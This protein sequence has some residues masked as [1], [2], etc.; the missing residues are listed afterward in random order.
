[1]ASLANG[2]QTPAQPTLSRGPTS[3]GLATVP[4]QRRS[5]VSQRTTAP[6]KG[7]ATVPLLA[8]QVLPLIC[9]LPEFLSPV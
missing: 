2:L 1:M 4:L 7:L 3:P 6:V 9:P 5:T 8:S